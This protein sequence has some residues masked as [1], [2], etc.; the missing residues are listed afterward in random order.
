MKIALI[1]LD[2]RPVNTRYPR[3]LADI[4]GVELLL[5][6][7]A[8]LSHYQ[9][10]A[11]TEEIVQWLCEAAATCDVLIVSC[12]MLGYGGLIHARRTSEPA[13]A[14]ISRLETLRELK[15]QK[16][17]LQIFGFNL[18]TRIGRSNDTTEEP[19]Y[20]G[21]YGYDFYRFSQLLDRFE[22]GQPV[23]DELQSIRARLRD[24][25]VSDF[26]R[27]RLRN[28]TIN[29]AALGMAADGVFDL[30]VISSDDTSPFGLGSREKRWVSEWGRRLELGE[31]LL[32][33]PG[34]DELGSILVARA[35]NQARGRAPTFQIDYAVPGGD[36]IT[37][38]FE[39]SP[40]R[41]TVERQVAAAGARV[42]PD[43]GD[44][45]LM[46]NPPRSPEHEWPRAYSDDEWDARFPHFE[47]A[48]ERL[49]AWMHSGKPAAVADVAHANGADGAWIA[50]ME[51]WGVSIDQLSAYGGWNTAGNTIGTT[52]AQA[53]MAWQTE[54]DST[55]Q[56][57]F[58]A[59]R[60]IEDFLYQAIVRD[61]AAHWL[62]TE[63]GVREP[64]PDRLDATARWI[65]HQLDERLTGFAPSTGIGYRIVPGSVRLPWSR[66]FEIDF[67][68]EP[69]PA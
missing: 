42:V 12:E 38:A 21:E 68:L 60:F 53:C 23:E 8:I 29:L 51:R 47:A 57:R 2:E 28:H 15:T 13:S 5:P 63:T 6:P 41:V 16:P 62:Q 61:E 3:M 46:V 32:M 26:L 9:Q 39:D 55:A 24:A 4:A 58:L 17:A 66:L 40:V 35:V 54:V 14:I 59:H 31:R 44:I 49:A 1:P 64:A 67:D 30:L 20:W 33:Y 10:P 50:L 19:P 27:R 52:V 65:E 69:D 18:I 48:A 37:A 34:A 36:A 56:K 25:D 11:S 7:G 43:G 45:L 22:Q